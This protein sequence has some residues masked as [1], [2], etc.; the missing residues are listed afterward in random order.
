MHLD[1][2]LVFSSFNLYRCFAAD[3]DSIKGGRQDSIRVENRPGMEPSMGTQ[4]ITPTAAK[5]PLPCQGLR[6]T[7]LVQLDHTT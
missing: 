4:M 2:Y 7:G 3:A 1:I 6:P 5:P